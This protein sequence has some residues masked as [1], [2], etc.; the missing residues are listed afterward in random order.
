VPHQEIDKLVGGAAE[1]RSLTHDDRI[2]CPDPRVRTNGRRHHGARVRRMRADRVVPRRDRTT[3]LSGEPGSRF[4][5]CL[6]LHD[7]CFPR[8]NG[9]RTRRQHGPAIRG[10]H[11]RARSTRLNVRPPRCAL[12]GYPVR[13]MLLVGPAHSHEVWIKGWLAG[14]LVPA[15][16][17]AHIPRGVASAHRP[18]AAAS[19][20]ADGRRRPDNLPFRAARQQ[21]ES[22]PVNHS[23]GWPTPLPC[24]IN[25]TWSR[26]LYP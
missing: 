22:W 13:S 2:R 1:V 10:A 11:V 23:S 6:R 9:K 19:P 12:P 15:F 4:G 18:R 26:C 5:S 21:S 17:P 3:V 24:G 8:R 25:N 14:S 20:V 7:P 16:R